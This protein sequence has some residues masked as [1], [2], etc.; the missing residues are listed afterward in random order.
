MRHMNTQGRDR[1]ATIYRRYDHILSLPEDIQHKEVDI[2]LM[3]CKPF[4]ARITHKACLLNQDKA[5]ETIDRGGLSNLK[6]RWTR[7]NEIRYAFTCGQCPKSTV[8]LPSDILDTWRE[9]INYWCDLFLESP[10]RLDPD[11]YEEHRRELARKN[12]HKYKARKEG[13]E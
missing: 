3:E 4:S 8:S 10:Y 7:D 6:V 9:N 2:P 5:R 11:S 1:G 12:W 13:R